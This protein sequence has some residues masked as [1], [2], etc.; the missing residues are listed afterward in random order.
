[1]AGLP[2]KTTNF[3]KTVTAMVRK[4]V[5]T[6]LREV[7][8]WLVPGAYIP[9]TFIPGTNLIRHVAYG[10]LA[11]ATSLIAIEGEPP[12]EE[13][14]SIGYA[15]YAAAQRGRLV[16]VTD[17]ALGM[18]PHQLMSIAADKVAYDAK[19]TVDRSI[20][21]AFA[22]GTGIPLTLAGA[23]MKASD[24]RKWVAILKAK[25]IPTFPDGFYIAMIHPA[26]VAD[27]MNDTEVG[28]W[29]EAS[30]YAA[31][32]QLL[33]GE[34]GRLGGM[35]FVETTIGT[36][37]TGSPDTYNTYV[38]SPDCFA[39]GDMQSIQTY[40]V[41]P[42][43]DHSDPLAQKALVGYKGMWGAKT[44]EVA[45]AGGARYGEAAAHAGTDLT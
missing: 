4:D 30:K 45:Q 37:T 41:R 43:G 2:T 9:G 20:A 11:V 25:L 12:D 5:L 36:S 21:A 28:G 40:M 14:L 22:A 42:G 24:V 29:I 15:E 18:N 27:L 13:P 23:V 6:N 3:D 1:M 10:D 26:V 7:S 33:N 19:M 38:L 17:V 44:I 39:F 31:P 8:R 35:R 34:I 16:S 32:G